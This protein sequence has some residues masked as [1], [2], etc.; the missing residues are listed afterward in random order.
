MSE[1][2]HGTFARNW[3]PTRAEQAAMFVRD[4]ILPAPSLPRVE[5][6]VR[7]QWVPST[8]RSAYNGAIKAGCKAR[9]T[10]AM[11][12]ALGANGKVAVP[13]QAS[14]VVAVQEPGGRRTVLH[15]VYKMVSGAPAWKAEDARD[16]RT[17]ED[18]GGMNKAKARWAT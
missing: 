14:I 16:G 2:P 4:R 6:D 8:V 13:Q 12:P 7:E 10:Y 5:I 3:P 17:G 15:W 9:A 11:G 1:I 18:L